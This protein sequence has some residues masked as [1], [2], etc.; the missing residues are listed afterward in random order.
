M[1]SWVP[2]TYCMGCDWALCHGDCSSEHRNR[3]FCHNPRC[4]YHLPDPARQDHQD[5][6]FGAIT[7][8]VANASPT[9]P[10]VCCSSITQP[11]GRNTPMRTTSVPDNT[12]SQDDNLFFREIITREWRLVDGHAFLAPG[13]CITTT[14]VA[15]ASTAIQ[16]GT[17]QPEERQTAATDTSTA[18]NTAAPAGMYVPDNITDEELAA[19]WRLL[20]Q[21]DISGPSG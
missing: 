15:T 19:Q 10:I 4:V 13:Q 9:S 12:R 2:P 7:T 1:T 20:A 16:T 11:S 3:H 14:S 21:F 5:V 8:A 18:S 6:P 17:I